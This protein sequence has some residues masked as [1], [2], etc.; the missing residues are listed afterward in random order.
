M[1]GRSLIPLVALAIFSSM[2]QGQSETTNQTPGSGTGTPYASCFAPAAYRK[3]AVWQ[4]YEDYFIKGR[5]NRRQ[6]GQRYTKGA[7]LIEGK[8]P[9]D[10]TNGEGPKHCTVEKF[11]KI[12]QGWS[13]HQLN[14]LLLFGHGLDEGF[15]VEMYPHTTSGY[16]LMMKRYNQLLDG[17]NGMPAFKGWV[18]LDD[19]GV[20][21]DSEFEI[22][23]CTN[24]VG[25]TGDN[26]FGIGISGQ[27]IR[28]YSKLKDHLVFMG[29]CKSA[30]LTDDWVASGAR[31]AIGFQQAGKPLLPEVIADACGK[32]FKRMDGQ[33]GQAS[34]PVSQAKLG[35]PNLVVAGKEATTL[36]P[37][38]LSVDAPCTINLGDTVTYT[39]DTECDIDVPGDI[40]GQ[41]N[42]TIAN[43]T[44]L[45]STTLQGTCTWVNPNHS[46][47]YGLTLYASTVR[48]DRNG[49]MLDGNQRPLW[50]NG[51]GPSQDNHVTILKCEDDCPGDYDES[52]AIDI[53]DIL[54]VLANWQSTGIEC[55]L[56]TLA[57]WSTECPL[58]ACCVDGMCIPETNED[59]C[60]QLDGVYLGDQSICQTSD[61]L[62]TGACCW[63]DYCTDDYLEEDCEEDNGQ[64]FGL[65]SVCSELSCWSPPIGTCCHAD[66][67]CT[68]NV[69]ASECD[70]T[71][72]LFRED[73]N[74]DL[75]QDPY[76]IGACCA[77]NGSEQTC[78]ETY[79]IECSATGGYFMGAGID[80]SQVTCAPLGTCCVPYGNWNQC[81]DAVPQDWCMLDVGGVWHE[82]TSCATIDD[83]CTTLQLGACCIGDFG[84][85]CENMSQ[86]ECVIDIG[87]MWH[88]SRY[89]HEMTDVD[90]NCLPLG[91]CCM[92]LGDQSTQCSS[93]LT[94]DDCLT[95]GGTFWQDQA[96]DDIQCTC[97]VGEYHDCYGNCFP[98]SW[99][100]DGTCQNGTM[101]NGVPIY[102]N[103]IELYCDYWDCDST[104]CEYE[105]GICCT[106]GYCWD[107][108]TEAICIGGHH[109][110]FYPDATC[111]DNSDLCQQ[112]G[113]AC[114]YPPDGCVDYM[115]EYG[116]I[117]EVNWPD[118]GTYY[119]DMTCAEVASKCNLAMGACCLAT[120]CIVTDIQDCLD[121]DGFYQ[122][123]L[124]DCD[125]PGCNETGACCVGGDA[126]CLDDLTENQCIDVPHLGVF[127]PDVSCADVPDLCNPERACC[128]GLDCMITD[129]QD[130][131]SQGGTFHDDLTDCLG[132][133]CCLP[134]EILDCSGM[135]CCPAEWLGDGQCD[136]GFWYNG[137]PIYLNCPEFNC[138]EGDCLPEECNYPLGACCVP[139]S[140]TLS[141]GDLLCV[142]S[143]QVDQEWCDLN[144]GTWVSGI[145]C[146]D[147]PCMTGACCVG[148]GQCIE[149]L[150]YSYC[151]TNGGT[152]HPSQGCLEVNCP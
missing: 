113:G 70:S 74:C 19:D 142:D 18:D 64:F 145:T 106:A 125:Y 53:G 49:R 14:T 56:C 75:C 28:K 120:N 107:N 45:N 12:L 76:P 79:E 9:S 25:E 37:T 47:S 102:L 85:Y 84:Q 119:P 31:V 66:G 128:L 111:A 32:M 99:L 139:A 36:S 150:T 71:D 69:T 134:G 34:R 98:G 38:V 42:C 112:G 52:Q 16:T 123:D 135:A 127:Y 136:N 58:G 72:D 130:C 133:P 88:G 92:T 54:Y 8:P 44:W 10:S 115:S 87:G 104:E 62:I 114:C 5:Y 109:G 94:E 131:S 68:T 48:S 126:Y 140:A 129:A 152:F 124:T 17:F 65:G 11:Y 23:T 20:D 103:C 43:E 96:C 4:R 100:G 40:D 143:S 60:L 27:F 29:A 7:F 26:W 30:S 117:Y 118:G 35:I 21:D 33:E 22:F 13:G 6:V 81:Y 105:S 1:S 132:S 67:S 89:C 61:C 3:A 144:S 78:I 137:V 51:K 77:N 73:D 63:D 110:I 121:Q 15:A 39:F 122:G 41:G 101:Y 80:C 91:A 46:C 50:R 141:E 86:E 59:C 90:G 116:C 151:V 95:W 147:V 57:A 97:P 108:M 24:A 138:D 82:N 148:D 93:S 83:D 149:G 146:L 2:L 55:L